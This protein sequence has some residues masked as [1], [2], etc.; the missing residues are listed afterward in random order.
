MQKNDSVRQN[1]R[2]FW[3]YGASQFLQRVCIALHINCFPLLVPNSNA[4]RARFTLRSP[5]EQYK[6]KQLCEPVRIHYACLITLQMAVSILNNSV[7]WCQLIWHSPGAQFS[8]Q[9]VL[10]DS[11]VQQGAG[12]DCWHSW[13]WIS[14]GAML[15]AFKNFITDRTS[16]SAGSGI[17]ASNFNRCNDVTMR[18]WGSPV[19]ACIMRRHFSITY[20]QSLHVI[21][22][23][24]AV[25]RVGNLLCGRPSYIM[26]IDKSHS[27]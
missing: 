15:C 3:L 2:A 11:F 23:L 14:I 20:T 5:P 8:E 24:Q 6:K 7:F 22:G 13:R 27:P 19:S 21:I 10:C 17:R 18:T 4:G 12:N 26:P 25:G 1:S 9:Q 16:Q